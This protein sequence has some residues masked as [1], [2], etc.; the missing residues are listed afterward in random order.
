MNILING[1]KSFTGVHLALGLAK[2]NF[3]LFIISSKI[4][5]K[6]TSEQFQMYEYI[7]NLD[8]IRLLELDSYENIENKILKIIPK[9]KYDAVILHGYQAAN[10]KSSEYD[11]L[12]CSSNSISWYFA[13]Q[14][15]DIIN[16]E[17]KLF[18]TGSYY[19]NSETVITPYALSKKISWLTLK[20]LSISN[21]KYHYLFPNPFGYGESERLCFTLLK[22]WFNNKAFEI[23]AP[24]LIRDNIPINFLIEDYINFIADRL[25]GNITENIE[26]SPS[27]YVHTNKEFIELIKLKL[28]KYYPHL[29]CELKIPNNAILISDSITGKSLIRNKYLH[30]EDLFWEKYFKSSF[31]R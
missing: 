4:N 8:N 5:T 2:K 16:N 7:S 9:V 1:I 14:K 22:S 17:T 18:Y 27:Y 29:K 31:L 24:N 11:F 26:F 23:G 6:L 28:V 15:N 13:L 30:K 10:Y 12:N 3:N 19:Q 25:K 21:S 20:S